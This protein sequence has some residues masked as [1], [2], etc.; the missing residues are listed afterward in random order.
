MR[1]DAI[2][3]QY[4]FFVRVCVIVTLASFSSRAAD[5]YP[6]FETPANH[7]SGVD[8][9]A[10]I[11]E[12]VFAVLIQRLGPR[13]EQRNLMTADDV[14]NIIEILEGLENNIPARHW[15]IAAPNDRMPLPK[16]IA[17]NG[18]GL[19]CG[20]DDFYGIPL[21]AEDKSS[22]IALGQYAWCWQLL[23]ESRPSAAFELL[24]RD[25]TNRVPTSTDVVRLYA[26]L[27]YWPGSKLQGA[28]SKD[29]WTQLHR[30]SNAV[31]RLIA[32]EKFDSVEQSPAELLALYRECLFGACSYLEVR[33][34]EAITRNKDFREEVAK[35]LEE[36]VASNPPPN[37]G[38]LPGLRNNF[39]N[40]VEGAKRV[41]AAIHNTD[42]PSVPSSPQVDPFAQ[43]TATPKPPPVVRHQPPT[44][45]PE[46][47]APPKSEEPASTTRLVWGALTLS[48][49][50]LLWLLLKKRQ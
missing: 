14:S 20:L 5:S 30:S 26:A 36:Y 41:I 9:E 22:L 17:N 2:P 10:V 45:T 48:A 12:P 3:H 42:Q 46:P 28:V 21:L 44:Q 40:L 49:T 25:S 24:S 27:G 47:K 6:K 33:A 37:D 15:P 31:N 8:L 19:N 50:A 13:L 16:V 38:T 4:L 32:L 23:W 43:N 7:V 34:L 18:H 29:A 35:L 1:T 11:V 39:P